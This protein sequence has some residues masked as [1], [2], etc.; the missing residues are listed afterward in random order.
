[1]KFL[2]IRRPRIGGAL[3]ASSKK[4]RE[5][6]E[7]AVNL[8]K[9]GRPDCGHGNPGGGGSATIANARSNAR[10]HENSAGSPLFLSSE[11][12]IHPLTDYT[13]YM[14]GVAAALEKQ[15]R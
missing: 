10:V 3:V 4:I 15:G 1:M 5:N 11:W 2:I 13:M 6:K 14:D 8:V 9:Q 7:R 12:E